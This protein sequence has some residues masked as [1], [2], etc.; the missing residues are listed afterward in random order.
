MTSIIA[1]SWT[2]NKIKLN[3]QRTTCFRCTQTYRVEVKKN[4]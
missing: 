3:K 4:I 2:Q 1:F